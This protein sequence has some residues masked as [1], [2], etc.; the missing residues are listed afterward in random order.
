MLEPPRSVRLDSTTRSVIASMLGRRPLSCN[1]KTCISLVSA[2]CALVLMATLNQMSGR[3]RTEVR[4]MCECC[5]MTHVAGENVP[6]R[7]PPAKLCALYKIVLPCPC[8]PVLEDPLARC[9]VTPSSKSLLPSRFPRPC[10]SQE[11]KN[12]SFTMSCLFCETENE[13]G[14]RPQILVAIDKGGRG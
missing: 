9:L 12:V 1:S 2:S 11:G 7:Q 13:R 3:S 4:D 8:F 6:R 5:T 10:I 14:K